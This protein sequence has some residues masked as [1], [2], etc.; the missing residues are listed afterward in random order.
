MRFGFGAS[1]ASNN[2]IMIMIAR[3]KHRHFV[4]FEFFFRKDYGKAGMREKEC[5]F[6]TG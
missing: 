4:I 5:A 3:F 6:G 2:K 1:Q